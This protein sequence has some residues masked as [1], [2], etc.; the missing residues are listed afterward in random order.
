MDKIR[1][2]GWIVLWWVIAK[3]CKVPLWDSNQGQLG[4]CAGWS[5]ANGHMITV[6]YQMMLGAFKFTL[7][8][9]LAMW[10]RTKN[11]SMNGGQSMSKVLMGGNQFGNYPVALVG[12]YAP[13]LTRDTISKIEAATDEATLHQFG[14]CRLPGGGKVLADKIVMCLRAGLVVAEVLRRS[15]GNSPKIRCWSFGTGK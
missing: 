1:S 12:E 3:T 7:I 11:W 10:V 6:L 14:A 4:S 13:R 9:P 8:N 15:F 2:A 5:A